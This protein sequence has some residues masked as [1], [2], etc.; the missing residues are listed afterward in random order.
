M[1]LKKKRP[2]LLV[3]DIRGNVDT[4][5]KKLKERK[6]DAIILA[7]A[8]LKRLKVTYPFHII[9]PRTIIPALGQGAI[10]L[11]VNKSNKEIKKIIAKLNHEKT[12]IETDC[13]RIFLEALDGSC[14]TPVGG[15]ALLKKIGK[16]K[17]I[18]F[19]YIAF[20]KDEVTLLKERVCFSIKNYKLESYELGVRVK[21]KIS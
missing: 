13:E 18:Y 10:A 5:I 12:F 6:F 2:D 1:Q 7:Y 14:K 15:Y 20:S 21:K 16:Q 8:G 4:R 19:N 17:K 3:K 9:D 11:V